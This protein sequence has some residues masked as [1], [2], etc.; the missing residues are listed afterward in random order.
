MGT[1]V[2][3]LVKSFFFYCLKRG[4]HH[5]FLKIENHLKNTLNIPTNESE[6]KNNDKI[7]RV[8]LICLTFPGVSLLSAAYTK[9]SI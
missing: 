8:K 1:I 5:P 6:A 3:S 2:G 4:S 9:L 7:I